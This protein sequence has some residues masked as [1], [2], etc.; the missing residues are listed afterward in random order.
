M[1]GARHVRAPAIQKQPSLEFRASVLRRL[2]GRS[3][4]T[5]S[6]RHEL[7][8][9]SLVFGGPQT[10]KEFVKLLL[11]LFEA[12]QRISPI[13]VEG[14]VAARPWLPPRARVTRCAGSIGP[15]VHCASFPTSHASAPY[16]EGQKPKS[17]H[18][19]DE[20][21]QDQQG[22]P[23]GLSPFVEFCNDRHVLAS[24]VN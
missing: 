12:P 10:A 3:A 11:F 15:T 9:L 8:E 22:D 14:I 5:A 7:I 18:P 17:E 6:I 24:Y 13:F 19:V 2:G 23:G 1:A 16:Q 4:A 21:G 20:E